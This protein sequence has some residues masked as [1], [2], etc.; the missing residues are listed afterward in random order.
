MS[1]VRL[2]AIQLCELNISIK[3][4]VNGH[5]TRFPAP[6]DLMAAVRQTAK[7]IRLPDGGS[8]PDPHPL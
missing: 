1:I 4:A 6:S 5:F 8:S 7:L 3:L 2:Y